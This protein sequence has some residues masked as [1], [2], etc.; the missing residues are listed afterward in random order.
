MCRADNVGDTGCP[1]VRSDLPTCPLEGSIQRMVGVGWPG[2]AWDWPS[3]STN[4]P[5]SRKHCSPS[6]I[7]IIVHTETNNS[8]AAWCTSE[9]TKDKAEAA[10]ECT[11]NA[12]TSWIREKLPGVACRDFP[13][14]CPYHPSAAANSPSLKWTMPPGG[15][16]YLKNSPFKDS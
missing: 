2:I 10:P 15:A 4:I 6:W 8:I 3:F 11:A 9:R 1:R 13:F 16:W 14:V 7:R 12:F 5:H